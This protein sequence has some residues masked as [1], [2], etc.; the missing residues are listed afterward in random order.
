MVNAG[1]ANTDLKIDGPMTLQGSGALTL[2]GFNARVYQ[3]DNM[4]VLTNRSTIHGAGQLGVGALN[5][6]NA[7]EG[8]IEGPSQ[9]RL[10][11]F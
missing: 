5:I 10:R 1:G 3:V 7:A 8:V 6:I 9:R 4:A 2:S 11:S